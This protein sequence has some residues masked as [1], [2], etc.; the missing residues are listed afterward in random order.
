LLAHVRK[1]LVN[2]VL[3]DD[4]QSFVRYAQAHET[5]L[6]FD[7]ESFELQI[8][9]KAPP[10]SVIGMRHIIAALRALPG[11]LTNPGHCVKSLIFKKVARERRA[12][13]VTLYQPC[14]VLSRG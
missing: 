3:V 7:P 4:A 13:S 6:G 2:A 12:E 5:L 9:Q 8:G 11:D 1:N 14:R 10:R